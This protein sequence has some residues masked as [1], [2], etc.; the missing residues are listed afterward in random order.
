MN[1]KNIIETA[2]EGYHF[3]EKKVVDNVKVYRFGNETGT[4]EMRCYDLLDGIQL[5][6]NN[7]N[8]ETSYQKIMPKPGILQID[9]CLEGCYEFKFDNNERA[10]IG[11]GDLSVIELAKVP[12][13]NSRIPTNHYVGLSLFIDM[14]VAQQSLSQYFP[15]GH[16][17]LFK[18]RDKLCENG[19]GLIMRSRHEIDHIISELYKVDERIQ[20]PYSIIKTLE[21]LLFLSLVESE[22]THK[23][24]SFSEPVYEAMQECYKALMANPFERYSISE[25]ARKYAIS[26]SSLK[27]CFSQLT[28]YSIG[29]F[30]KNNCLEEAAQLLED[31][32]ELSIGEIAYDAGYTNQSKFSA[33]FKKYFGETPQQYR[34][35]LF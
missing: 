16:I 21:L 28:G 11:K 20:F 33:A 23:L 26:E 32:P 7:L 22:D 5:T 27:R 17:D 31:Y 15:Y 10:F 12:F 4:G 13:K 18:M 8:M 24:P 25:L 1:S 30:I 34:N 3:A 29:Q 14:A 2:Y 6:Y 9:H 35:K 19:T